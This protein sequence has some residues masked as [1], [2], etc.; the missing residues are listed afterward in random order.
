MLERD[1]FVTCSKFVEFLDGYMR[2]LSE[3]L[4]GVEG[5]IQTAIHSIMGSISEVSEK[6]SASKSQADSVLEEVYLAPTAETRELVDAVQS[7]VDDIIASVQS[8]SAAASSESEDASIA[9]RRLAGRFSKK[10]ESMSTLDASVAG[11]LTTMMG[12]LSAGDVIFQRIEH[13]TRSLN[14][15][16]L[17]LSYV[18]LDVNARFNHAAIMKLKQDLLSYTYRQ[19]SSEEER[20]IHES[21]VSTDHAA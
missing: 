3:Q 13:L 12:A 11:L 19:Y 15:M 1:H 17:G 14:A 9:V 7:S 4:I 10:M 2:V 16:N 18:L 6:T 21:V 20:A 5:S 8:E